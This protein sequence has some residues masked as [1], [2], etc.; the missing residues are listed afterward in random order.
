MCKRKVF[1]QYERAFHV[2][3]DALIFQTFQGNNCTCKASLQCESWY[4]WQEH[5]LNQLLIEV[6]RLLLLLSGKYQMKVIFKFLSSPDILK[7]WRMAFLL[8]PHCRKPRSILPNHKLFKFPLNCTLIA[9][10]FITLSSTDRSFGML[11]ASTL[12]LHWN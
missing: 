1:H 4:A 3:C 9:F 11:S 2:E 12:I 7:W 8:W 6:I 10:V 5:F